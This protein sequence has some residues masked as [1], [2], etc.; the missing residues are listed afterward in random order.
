MLQ[1]KGPGVPVALRA[2]SGLCKAGRPPAGLRLACG[3]RRAAEGVRVAP[4]WLIVAE[5][6][7]RDFF[8]F[9]FFKA[10]K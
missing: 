3:V 9:F 5:K 6:V 7:P 10:A 8:F 2:R 1:Q 4:W